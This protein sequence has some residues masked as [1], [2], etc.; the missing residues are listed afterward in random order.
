M[1]LIQQSIIEIV[2][3]FTIDERKWKSIKLLK[4]AWKG[5]N[6]YLECCKNNKNV[7]STRKKKFPISKNI[8][9]ERLDTSGLVDVIKSIDFFRV[10]YEN[11]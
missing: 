9:K 10:T 4:T 6:L 2:M 3:A 7:P 8:H 11:S 5:S 1:A